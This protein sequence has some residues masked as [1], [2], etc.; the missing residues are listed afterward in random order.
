MVLISLPKALQQ[1]QSELGFE[2]NNHT[3]ICGKCD[4]MSMAVGSDCFLESV[5]GVKPKN[6]TSDLSCLPHL[7]FI[8]ICL[9]G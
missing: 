7:K 3:M 2:L 5:V 6:F 1:E 4:L 8:C 9:E